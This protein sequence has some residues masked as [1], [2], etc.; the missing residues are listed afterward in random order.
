MENGKQ[1]IS[2]VDLGALLA[3]YGVH[4]HE[5]QRLLHMAERQDDPE[6]TG[7][8]VFFQGKDEIDFFRRRGSM[9]AQAG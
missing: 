1:C 8:G 3:L 5:R 4:G 6:N 9:L 7:S 2:D